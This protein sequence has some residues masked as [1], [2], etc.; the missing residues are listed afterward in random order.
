MLVYARVYSVVFE[1]WVVDPTNI[2]SNHHVYHLRRLSPVVYTIAVANCHNQ[3]IYLH[4]LTLYSAS[5]RFTCFSLGN[6]TLQP[7]DPGKMDENS[8]Y[9]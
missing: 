7:N 4:E 2:R 3:R 6:L 8:P 5:I 9:I 1:Q